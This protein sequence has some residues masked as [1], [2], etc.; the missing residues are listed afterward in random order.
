MSRHRQTLEARR[1][2][3]RHLPGHALILCGPP[4]CGKSL[5]QTLLTH[6]IGGREADPSLWLTGETSFNDRLWGAKHLLMGDK[7]P[8]DDRRRRIRLR[9]EIKELVANSLYPL[10]PKG[11]A[12][13][14]LRP[15]W[16]ITLICNDDHES[17]QLLPPLNEGF[18]D[19]VILLRCYPPKAPFPTRTAAQ[20]ER[21]FQG[22][23]DDMPAFLHAVENFEVPPLIM[24]DRFGVKEFHHPALVELITD[25]SPVTPFGELIQEWTE[26]WTE[27]ER[28]GPALKLYGQLREKVRATELKGYVRDG[29]D[30]GRKLRE[31]S[32]LDGWKDRIEQNSRRFGPNKQK[33]TIWTIKKA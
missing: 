4:D 24:G 18:R 11:K 32:R 17:A 3:E 14:S 29:A 6:L 28:S 27:D 1:N 15:I 33:Q 22:L 8:A 2:P 5:G 21:F 13:L 16:R 25:L 26:E 30:F 19:K 7:S 20:N 31:L 12:M 10:H 9:D 23:L